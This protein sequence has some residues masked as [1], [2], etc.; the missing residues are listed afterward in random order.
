MSNEAQEETVGNNEY[1]RTIDWKQGL[2]ISMGVP[3]FVLPSIGYFASFLWAG[4]ILLWIFSIVQGFLQVT[5]YGELATAFPDESGLPGYSQRVF[6]DKNNP[7]NY[8]FG[9]FIG[10]FSAWGYWF[11]WNSALAIYAILIAGALQG[12]IPELAGVNSTVLSLIVGA[13]TFGGLMMVS[14][15]G[16]GNG[17]RLGL[18]LAILSI[19]PLVA[20]SIGPM[21]T[22]SFQL[23][24][25]TGSWWPTGW[26]WDLNGV[27]ILLGL[28]GI[29]E[30]SACGFEGAAMFGPQY[31]N[32]KSDVPK[33]IFGSGLVCLFF[34]FIV[35][36][37]CTGTLGV[38]GVVAQGVSPFVPMAQTTFGS[39]AGA[40]LI[41]MLVAA[42]ILCILTCYLVS[43][44]A[45]QTMSKNGYLPGPFAKLNKHGV[46]VRA[47]FAITAFNMALITMGNPVAIVSAAAFGYMFANGI[48]MFAY[49]KA[50]T[51]PEMSK[52]PRAFK[53]PRGY[54]WVALT[55]GLFN[56]PLC[57][58]GVAYLNGTTTGWVPVFVG[59]G[60]LLV[61]VPIW[62]YSRREYAQ[63][64]KV[65]QKE[66]NSEPG[67]L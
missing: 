48:S 64:E 57:L 24:N 5:A 30:W 7:S 54:K 34:Y 27:L 19:V 45:M 14:A 29:A 21:V 67:G 4:A 31:K 33:A 23:S 9:K 15:R 20:L 44:G 49:Y 38:S 56:V 46:P 2:Y 37:S 55:V 11:A 62:W 41:V 52:L 39:V 35:Q 22:G 50:K 42:M 61:Y 12:L 1:K 40:V 65:P 3:V 47:M 6:E 26:N 43:A 66:T 58:I 36:T 8:S 60:I 53:A 25:I 18:F 13:V 32:P 63:L 28:A 16:I 17:A 10:G 59:A 51:D